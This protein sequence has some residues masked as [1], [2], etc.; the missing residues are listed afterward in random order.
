MPHTLQIQWSK[1]WHDPCQN[2]YSSEFFYGI[3]SITV[4]LS[5]ECTLAVG[6][7]EKLIFIFHNQGTEITYPFPSPFILEHF[8][9][10][11]THYTPHQE[12]NSFIF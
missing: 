4:F 5:S 10:F 1:K 6:I 7:V 11:T 2:Q 12:F 3:Q 9:H 8:V